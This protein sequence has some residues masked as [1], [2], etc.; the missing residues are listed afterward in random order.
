[1]RRTGLITAGAIAGVVVAGA[2]AVAANVGILSAADDSEIGSLS[3]AGDLVAPTETQVVDV[4]VDDPPGT[5]APSSQPPNDTY[6]FAVDSAGTV[7][8]ITTADG[9]RLGDVAANPGWKWSLA[10]GNATTLTASFTSG[11]R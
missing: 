6:E 10:Q 8:V 1:M 9:I 7:S 4:Y 3:A 2:T 5:V 11:A